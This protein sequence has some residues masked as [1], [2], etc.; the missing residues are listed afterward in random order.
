MIGSCIVRSTMPCRAS[1]VPLSPIRYRCGSVN[2]FSL[3]LVDPTTIQLFAMSDREDREAGDSS[4]LPDESTV[5]GNVQ[6]VFSMFKTYLEDRFDEKGKEF[7]LRTKAEK[8]IVQLQYKG[9][10][11]Q[12][13]LNARIDSIFDGI[14]AENQKPEHGARVQKRVKQG[15][16]LIRKRQKLIK[17]ADRNKDGW[18]VV[19]EYESDELA[20]GSED[21]KR[22]KKAKD[23]AQRKRRQKE[24]Q[25]RSRDKRPKVSAV[26]NDSQLFRGM[27]VA[28]GL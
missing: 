16:E 5:N 1:V 18:Q 24:T 9:N 27:Y 17:I 22:L 20:S 4:A 19:E 23:S 25:A 2:S 21:E 13:E 8:E 7:E 6:Q 10:Q 3:S 12:F 11:K 28:P 26:G 14:Q 15:K